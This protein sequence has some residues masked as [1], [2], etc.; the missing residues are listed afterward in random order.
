MDNKQIISFAVNIIV[1]GIESKLSTEKISEGL[2]NYEEY[3]N[4]QSYVDENALRVLNNILNTLPEMIK[5]VPIYGCDAL[6]DLML[7]R[8]VKKQNESTSVSI[9]I[10]SVETDRCG[11]VKKDRCGNPIPKGSSTA[12]K[13]RCGN[14][15]SVTKDRCGNS[16][17]SNDSCSGGRS[18][19]RSRC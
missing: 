7:G 17:V 14:E 1:N 9:P 5:L 15:T 12:T 6:A 4:D 19:G 16:R 3:L 13:D 8:T 18:V 11:N 10:S 2:K